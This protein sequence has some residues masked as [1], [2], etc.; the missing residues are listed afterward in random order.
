M[1]SSAATC[2]TRDP[3]LEF[4]GLCECGVYVG[5]PFWNRNAIVRIVGSDTRFGSHECLDYTVFAGKG[6]IICSLTSLR[7][8]GSV[9]IQK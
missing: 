6:V 9:F 4:G 5:R 3:G 7:R 2:L 8:F 1:Y